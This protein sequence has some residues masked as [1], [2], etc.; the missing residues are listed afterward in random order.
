MLVDS[1]NSG[2]C[3]AKAA[4]EDLPSFDL[5]LPYSLCSKP[6]PAWFYPAKTKKNQFSVDCQQLTR[7]GVK[8]AGCSTACSD[9]IPTANVSAWHIIT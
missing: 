6:A 9:F 3:I 7:A 5:Q 8:S 4:M 1:S 2:V